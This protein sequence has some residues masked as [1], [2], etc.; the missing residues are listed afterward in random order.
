MFLRERHCSWQRETWVTPQFCTTFWW[1]NKNGAL[2]FPLDTLLSL[3]IWYR[4]GN[5]SLKVRH[6]NQT[7][8]ST[9]WILSLEN[10]RYPERQYGRLWVQGL[11]LRYA[12][13]K[14]FSDT[15]EEA[16]RGVI[17]HYL[18]EGRSQSE[19]EQLASDKDEY[20]NTLFV[21]E[22]GRWPNIKNLKHDIGS[23]LNFRR[24]IK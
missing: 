18:A 3:L 5:A 16:Q 11:H 22:R 21:S 1:Q 13:L 14:R 19:A 23:E 15:F 8:T 17:V 6:H 2:T 20:D 7:H 12:A 9:N 10:P 24:P 4:D